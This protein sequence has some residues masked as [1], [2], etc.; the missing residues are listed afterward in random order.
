MARVEIRGVTKSFGRVPAVDKV[1]FVAQDGDLITLLGPSGC[2]KTTTLNM[3]AG[4]IDPDDGEIFIDNQAIQTTPSHKRNLGMVFQNFALFPH[5]TVFEN[6]AFGLSMRRIPK[7]EIRRKVEAALE[8]VELS[9]FEDRYRR[10]LSGGQAQRVA[11]ARAVVIEPAVLLLDEPFSALD[12]SLRAQL[13]SDVRRIQKTLG[14]TTVFVTHDQ[15]EALSMSDSIVLMRRGAIEQIG[16]P[17]EVYEHPRNKFVASFLGDANLL[18]GKVV[19]QSG[20]RVEFA[21]GGTVL[22]AMAADARIP[23]GSAGTL[24]LRPER[25][26]ITDDRN[27]ENAIVGTIKSVSFVGSATTYVVS[28]AAGILRVEAHNNDGIA[29]REQDQSVVLSFAPN[30]AV[31]IHEQ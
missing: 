15:A 21:W 10:Q 13:R 18:P 14:I 1:S 2:G 27:A 16:T 4:F 11:L 29:I 3:I 20:D 5:M 22:R 25:L 28:S 9:S 31:V 12:A 8:M 23:V 7:A 30:S 26:R 19:S 6:V 24:A 17:K